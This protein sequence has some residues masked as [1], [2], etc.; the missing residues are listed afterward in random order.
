MKSNFIKNLDYKNLVLTILV[1]LFV[2]TFSFKINKHLKM[3]FL[4]ISLLICIYDL[5]YLVPFL[6]TFL[7][8]N[9]RNKNVE[10]FTQ[11]PIDV[12][13]QYVNSKNYS[14]NSL[15]NRF[16]KEI[17]R[18]PFFNNTDTEYENIFKEII[19]KRTQNSEISVFNEGADTEKGTIFNRILNRINPTV[20][21]L[22]DILIL[23]NDDSIRINR[24]RIIESLDS[25]DSSL[26]DRLLK[27]LGLLF[28]FSNNRNYNTFM[29]KISKQI[30]LS[31]I[32][33]NN[34]SPIKPNTNPGNSEYIN[35]NFNIVNNLFNE[36]RKNLLQ[37][38][39]YLFKQNMGNRSLNEIVVTRNEQEELFNYDFNI[40][41]YLESNSIVTNNFFLNLKEIFIFDFNFFRPE[42]IIKEYPPDSDNAFKLNLF[43]EDNPNILKRIL[44]GNF[45]N[46]VTRIDN[47]LTTS[48]NIQKINRFITEYK[49]EITDTVEDMELFDNIL[50]PIRENKLKNTEK[51]KMYFNLYSLILLTNGNTFDTIFT[52]RVINSI[53]TDI[54][55]NFNDK[56]LEIRNKIDNTNFELNELDIFY[57]QIFLFIK[58][59]NPNYDFFITDI[60]GEEIPPS[61][62]VPEESSD[63][64]YWYS[65]SEL[66]KFFD[67]NEMNDKK[68][69]ELNKYY[70]AMN[71]NNPNL[72]EITKQANIQNNNL[73]IE[74]V[75][76]NNVVDKFSS[77]TYE[78]IDDFIKL[79]QD[80]LK[81]D[82]FVFRDFINNFIEILTKKDRELSVGFIF[83]C[84]A[85][86]IYFIEDNTPKNEISVV[87]YLS[88]IKM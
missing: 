66:K 16:L 73:K 71:F 14:G 51:L 38:V 10:H 53:N 59:K 27:K 64:P 79:T 74:K 63:N 68:E 86:L 25:L 8:I 67:V 46:I 72:Q 41:E 84:L 58:I 7:I 24:E 1:T 26:E 30:G 69:T 11:S 40:E 83:I 29:Y 34:L 12:Y 75:S 45:E 19:K 76:F 4:L 23:E 65:D 49:G 56:N 60:F 85:L 22:F 6:V 2:F 18:V 17:N 36:K 48:P 28:S 52:D 44:L 35:N 31:E 3:F 42:F 70:R 81:E 21:L 57:N 47:S 62:N 15:R 50:R 20:E 78:I 88:Q 54:E 80:S 39:I 9:L 87:D 77:N 43:Y 82:Q 33:N 32:Y 55:D 5:R 13:E 61:F 37:A